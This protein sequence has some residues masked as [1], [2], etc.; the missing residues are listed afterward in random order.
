MTKK[1]SHKRTFANHFVIISMRHRKMS[2]RV[3]CNRC[4]V[5]DCRSIGRHQYSMESHFRAGFSERTMH[6][7]S[8]HFIAL[9]ITFLFF[10]IFFIITTRFQMYSP[11]IRYANDFSTVFFRS[12]FRLMCVCAHDGCGCRC[13][14]H[15]TFFLLPNLHIIDVNFFFIY[16]VDSRYIRTQ[17]RTYLTIRKHYT[18]M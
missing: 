18:P 11:L 3:C 4:A 6:A 12:G 15:V 7:Y 9:C 1:H 5:F 13:R 2:I 14:H 10:N 17:T 8:K 16:A